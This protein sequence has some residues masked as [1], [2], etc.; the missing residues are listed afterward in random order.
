MKAIKCKYCERL[1]QD[2]DRYIKHLE[3]NHSDSIPPGMSPDQF[4]YFLKTGR[5]HGNCVICKK[6]TD[7]NPKT[8]KYKRFCNNP[9]C[10]DTYVKQFQS[11]M[12]TTHGKINL[13]NDPE[14]QR[15]MLEHRSISGKYQWS[16]KEGFKT[17]TGTYEKDF[18]EFLDLIMDFPFDDVISPSPHTYSYIY[19]NKRHF[20][21]P[22]FFI[23]SLNLEIEIKD[24]GDNPN[25]HPKIQTVDKVKEQLKDD[26]MRTNG[27][28]NYLKITNKNNK[29]FFEYLELAKKKNENNDT[30]LIF[31]P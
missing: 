5:M 10:K 21:F 13:L 6:P 27:N 1:F 18:L 7:W 20:Y 26:V 23:P 11:R 14:Q 16:T 24:G 29:K 28:F 25:M 22:D 3:V 31:M 30:S 4:Y 19:E 8:H 12:I 9:K 15:K 2:S 17:Y